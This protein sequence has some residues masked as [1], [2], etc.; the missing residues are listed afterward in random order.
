MQPDWHKIWNNRVGYPHPHA[1]QAGGKTLQELIEI[2]GFH[3]AC[4]SHSVET[5][6]RQVANL[7]NSYSSILTERKKVFEIGCGAGAF[8]KVLEEV[9]ELDVGGVDFAPT[10]LQHAR[11][12]LRAE[13]GLFESQACSDVLIR[14]MDLVFSHSVFHY[15]PS[16]QYALD[17]LDIMTSYLAKD[18]PVGLA[19]LDIRDR[20]KSLEYFEYRTGSSDEKAATDL[21]HRLFTKSFFSDALGKLGFDK[22]EIVD[23]ENNG[24]GNSLY[25]FNV[26]AH[27]S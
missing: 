9:Y 19:V 18:K 4:G 21:G 7:V 17:V 11:K 20:N 24:Y 6:K 16:E 14:S 8:L 22:I 15:F 23:L 10:L 2:D 5:F 1:T 3:G 12:N 27:R 13:F 26:F 25:S